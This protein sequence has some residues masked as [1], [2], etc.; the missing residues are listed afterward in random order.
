MRQLAIT[1]NGQTHSCRRSGEIWFQQYHRRLSS[2]NPQRQRQSHGSFREVVSPCTRHTGRFRPNPPGSR[3]P[4]PFLPPSAQGEE[5]A[6]RTCRSCCP[7]AKPEPGG[8]CD[9]LG[10]AHS[11]CYR[12]T[13]TPTAG[14]GARGEAFP[15]ADS[16]RQRPPQKQLSRWRLGG[17]GVRPPVGRNPQLP[18]RAPTAPPTGTGRRP[19]VAERQRG[20]APPAAGPLASRAA[21]AVQLPPPTS[22]SRRTGPRRPEPPPYR[23]PHGATTAAPGLPSRRGERPPLRRCPGWEG[24]RPTPVPPPPSFTHRLTGLPGSQS[25]PDLSRSSASSPGS[26][27]SAVSS[28]FALIGR[29]ARRRSPIGWRRRDGPLGRGGRG[30]S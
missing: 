2:P 6:L 15:A 21:A 3:L 13:N 7:R 10:R 24:P 25:P 11:A 19:G 26:R 16:R 9:P 22:N 4:K 5:A 14:S 1:S 29:G 28:A 20:L 23:S 27:L 8:S 30:V 12:A 18:G 17:H